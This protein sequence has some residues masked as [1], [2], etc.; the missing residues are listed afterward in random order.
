MPAAIFGA[1]TAGIGLVVGAGV[2]AYLVASSAPVDA[3]RSEART[4]LDTDINSFKTSAQSELTTRLRTAM[5]EAER[6]IGKAVG[7]REKELKALAEQFFKLSNDNKAEQKRIRDQAS[8]R[9]QAATAARSSL[10]SWT[11]R[12]APRSPAPA[13]RIPCE[14]NQQGARPPPSSGR[15]LAI[16]FGTTY[17]AA[18][19]CKPGGNA[20][21]VFF[22]AAGAPLPQTASCIWFG[23]GDEPEV[24]TGWRAENR[25]G[26]DPE[27]I[28][29]TP[30]VYLGKGDAHVLAGRPRPTDEVVGLVLKAIYDEATARAAAPEKIVLTHPAHWGERS[31]RL[32][33]AAAAHAGLGEPTL[34]SEPNAAVRFHAHRDRPEPG[35]I[36]AVFDIGGGTADAAVLKVV[37]KDTV[38]LLGTPRGSDRTGGEEFDRVLHEWVIQSSGATMR[39]PGKR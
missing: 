23:E 15:V 30:K 20:E 12:S 1:A 8:A 28:L 11:S 2:A 22:E 4:L 33:K 3:L 37:D 5:R 7:E 29:L 25:A 38:S 18:A 6:Q 35:T 10:S 14:R 21:A 16:D 17:S 13:R 34:L 39:T 26:R 27:R 32:L 31:Q 9:A 24:A 36:L 19:F